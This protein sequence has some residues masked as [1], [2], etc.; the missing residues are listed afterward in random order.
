MAAAVATPLEGQ[1]STIAGLDSM[2]STSA[3]RGTT[4][5]T[6]QFS[7][8][9]SIDAAAQDVQ[10]AIS[11]AL[12]KLPQNMPTPPSFRK[13]NPA[14][15]P[16]FYI[17]MS[18]PT[19]PLPIMN[20]YAQTQLAQRLSTIAGVAQ[21]QVTGLRNSPYAF[22]PTPTS[23]MPA[24]WASTNCNRPSRKPTSISRWASSTGRRQSFAIK[25]NGQLMTAAAY[26]RSSSPGVTVRRSA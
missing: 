2:S 23:S 22:A 10:S 24:A 18:S 21:V 25:D 15:S 13:V 14:D 26:R 6:L 12:R 4:S 3:E 9:R 8:D 5:I 16:I 20:D 11:A 1:F 17:A 19:L 7:L